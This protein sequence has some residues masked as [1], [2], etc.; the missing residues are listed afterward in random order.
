MRSLR[1]AT[2]FVTRTGGARAFIEDLDHL[3]LDVRRTRDE[4]AGGPRR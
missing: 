3:T 2:S 1:G 4:T